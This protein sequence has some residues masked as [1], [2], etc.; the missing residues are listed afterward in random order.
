MN[1]EQIDLTSPASPVQCVEIITRA[2]IVR[3]NANLVTV[4][5]GQESVSVEIELNLSRIGVRKTRPGGQWEIG[6][7]EHTGRG[8]EITLRR[9]EGS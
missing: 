5:T 3:V 4:A 7:R 8:L 6:Q 1:S 2:G 9:E